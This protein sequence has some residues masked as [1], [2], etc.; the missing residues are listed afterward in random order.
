[1]I[2]RYAVKIGGK[3]RVVELR[4]GNGDGA[5]LEIL[6]DG[7]RR[8]VDAREV[9]PG[10][11]SLMVGTEQVI[12]QID[13]TVPKLTVE[14][15][16]PGEPVIVGVEIVEARSPAVAELARRPDAGTTGPA[17]LRAPMPGRVVKVLVKV[18]ERVAAGQPAVVVE[19]MK[20]ENELRA[21]RAG[22]VLNLRCTEGETVEAGQDLVVI[23]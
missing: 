17:V 4:N 18:G 16:R 6:V 21:P 19:A 14:I 13:G 2:H 7:Q 20:M 5:A 22:L 10:V 3:E 23:E 8:A 15:G 12:A 9:E 11:W 1:M